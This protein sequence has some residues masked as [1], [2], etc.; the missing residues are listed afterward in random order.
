MVVAQLIPATGQSA[1]VLHGALGAAAAGVLVEV[2]G[3]GAASPLLHAATSRAIA[4]K[5]TSLIDRRA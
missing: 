1:S 5:I 4:K 2:L 3:V